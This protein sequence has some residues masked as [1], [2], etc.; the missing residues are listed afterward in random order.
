[1]HARGE[2]GKFTVMVDGREELVF[3]N[4]DNIDIDFGAGVDE[5]NFVGAE[6]AQTFETNGPAKITLSIKPDSPGFDRFV[7]LRLNRGK[8]LE[9]RSNVRF[10]LTGAVNF[11]DAGRARWRFPDC[12]VSDLKSSVQGRT[13]KFTGGLMLICDNPSKMA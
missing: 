9:Q 5:E 7:E 11:G 4:L 12:K 8:S 3:R 10:D 6:T 1:M 2:D 13:G